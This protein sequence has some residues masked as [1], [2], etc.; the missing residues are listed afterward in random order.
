MTHSGILST[1]LVYHFLN[2]KFPNTYKKDPTVPQIYLREHL[3]SSLRNQYSTS[4]SN[5][6]SELKNLMTELHDFLKKN[7]LIE[8]AILPANSDFM[9][10]ILRS[11]DINVLVGSTTT[12]SFEYAISKYSNRVEDSEEIFQLVDTFGSSL[13]LNF[14]SMLM[15]LRK[16]LGDLQSPISD[17]IKMHKGQYEFKLSF[18]TYLQKNALPQFELKD[19]IVLRKILALFSNFGVLL[20]PLI[21][22]FIAEIKENLTGGKSQ[23]GSNTIENEVTWGSSIV[24]LLGQSLREFVD[25]ALELTSFLILL[26]KFITNAYHPAQGGLEIEAETVILLKDLAQVLVGLKL[27]SQTSITSSAIDQLV[28]GSQTQYS[29]IDQITYFTLCEH[30]KYLPPLFEY[31]ANEV[32]DYPS[33][34]F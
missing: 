25:H 18:A 5:N 30:R 31:S 8:A 10:L 4:E 26:T 3:F 34:L 14:L 28:S 16:S 29:F 19:Q 27:L 6:D 23:K 32:R 20:D 7:D 33:Q 9:P 17:Y 22:Q 15:V 11:T 21:N 12:E 24:Y 2:E 13:T 1:E